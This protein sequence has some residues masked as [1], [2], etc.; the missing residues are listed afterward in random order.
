[1]EK[2][3]VIDSVAVS[4]ISVDYSRA[5]PKLGSVIPPYNSL[6]DKT[7]SAYLSNYGVSDLLRKTGQVKRES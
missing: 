7:I 1:M 2:S 4:N 3:F 5:N 6:D